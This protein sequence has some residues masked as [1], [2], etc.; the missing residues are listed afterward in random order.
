MKK[1]VFL[2]IGPCSLVE[3]AD[4]SEVLAATLNRASVIIALTM[5]A[6][7]TSE[8]S[9]YFYQATRR[10]SPEDRRLRNR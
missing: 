10:Y 1:A 9:L 3:V 2:V 7:S 8:K 6:A 5:E 4:V